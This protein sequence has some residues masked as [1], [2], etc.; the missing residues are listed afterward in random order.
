MKIAIATD[1][2]QVSAHFGH[3]ACY[4]LFEVEES[5][6]EKKILSRT[7]IDTP[8]HQPGML[9]GFLHEKGADVVIAGGMGPRAQDLFM[10]LNIRPYIGV[11]GKIDDVIRDFLAGKMQMG[12][13]LCDHSHGDG[14]HHH[15][16]NHH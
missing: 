8:A 3:C 15:D 5:G 7:T 9:P 10:E 11:T 2:D 4:T 14:S 12:E 1:Q 6:T 16:C 13:S